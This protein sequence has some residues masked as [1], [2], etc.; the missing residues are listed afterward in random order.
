MSSITIS[1]P[2]L[3]EEGPK[4]YVTV[5]ISRDLEEKYKESG[6]K[7]PDPMSLSALIDTGASN[8]LIRKDIPGKLGLKPI[9][10]AKIATVQSR[11]HVCSVYWIR[12]VIKMAND[13]FVHTGPFTAVPLE[14]QDISILI[15]RDVLKHGI[16]TYE[17][18]ANKYTIS[19]S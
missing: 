2:N 17:G 14:E 8:C 18:K 1:S 13:V 10:T 15:G 7:V 6:Q 9:G 5:S 3:C 4:L 16:F 11:G 19:L 12:L